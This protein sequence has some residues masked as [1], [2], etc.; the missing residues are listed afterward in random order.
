MLYILRPNDDTVL[1]NLHLALSRLHPAKTWE[2]VIKEH[3]NK[4][5]IQQ[6]NYMHKLCRIVSEHTGY[7][8]EEVKHRL[9]DSLGYWVTFKDK[10][11]NMKQTLKST[12]DMDT[13]ELGELIDALQQACQI[14]GLT[15]PQPSHY[16]YE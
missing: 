2:V 15:Y 12:A 10:S 5:T 3:K 7:T 14:L 9:V 16:G 13:K 8:T 4:R 1:N 6:N 11:G